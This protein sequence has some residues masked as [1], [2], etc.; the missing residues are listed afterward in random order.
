MKL[1]YSFLFWIVN[2]FL[3]R[4]TSL[5]FI[6]PEVFECEKTQELIKFRD[7]ILIQSAPYLYDETAKSSEKNGNFDR[8]SFHFGVQYKNQMAAYVRLTPS[9]F[10][11][12]SLSYNWNIIS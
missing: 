2:S 1:V 4:Q 9:K 6:G 10:E 7:S 3:K 8:R 11:L 5:T 12:S